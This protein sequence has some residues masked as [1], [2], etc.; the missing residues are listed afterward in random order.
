M[1]FSP[2]SRCTVIVHVTDTNDLDP[3]FSPSSYSF[4]LN[5]DSRIHTSV[6]R[7]NADDADSGVNGEIY[8][9]IMRQPATVQENN[10]QFFYNISLL[11]NVFESSQQL[12]L[13]TCVIQGH[14][15]SFKRFVRDKKRDPKFQKKPAKPQICNAIFVERNTF[16]IL[17][18]FSPISECRIQHISG[19]IFHFFRWHS[20][21][22]SLLYNGGSQI[23]RL[24]AI[25]KNCCFCRTLFP[26][27]LLWTPSLASSP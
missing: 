7:V 21:F 14:S 12:M 19:V 27:I 16:A 26:S 4:D 9:S 18:A 15:W 22:A 6:G 23:L 8:Y 17:K 11:Q 24:S 5:E 2:S 3:F 20:Q 10:R 25:A 1:S 13:I